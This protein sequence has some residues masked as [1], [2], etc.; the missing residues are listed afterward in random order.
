MLRCSVTTCVEPLID[1]NNQVYYL[2]GSGHIVNCQRCAEA[3]GWGELRDSSVMTLIKRYPE[4]SNKVMEIDKPLIQNKT[5]K[6]MDTT[7]LLQ[8]LKT[9]ESRQ[10]MSRKV[11]DYLNLVIDNHMALVD[12]PMPP[13]ATMDWLHR[14]L[15][16]WYWHNN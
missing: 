8:F 15:S 7:Q 6:E 2:L 12:Q 10:I 16:L 13:R 9:S 1:S 14:L 3:R 11:F 4:K 5:L